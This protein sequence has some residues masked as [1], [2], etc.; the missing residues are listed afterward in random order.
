MKTTKTTIE[1][2]DE[3]LNENFSYGVKSNKMN[4]KDFIQF[5][6]EGKTANYC[7]IERHNSFYRITVMKGR[8]M[9]IDFIDSIDTDDISALSEWIKNKNYMN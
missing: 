5:S 9:F 2:A 7:R 1:I 3:F 4:I 8:G 6:F